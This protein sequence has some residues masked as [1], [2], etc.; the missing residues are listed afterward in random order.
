MRGR[1]VYKLAVQRIVDLVTNACRQAGLPLS[2]LDWLIPHQMNQRII[3]SACER[4]GFPLEKTF[5]NI[6]RYGNTSSASVPL[7][8]DE[9]IREGRLRRG[10]HA[11]LLAIGGGLAWGSLLLKY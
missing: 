2:R 9:A 11:L 5:I 1:E 10:Q 6:D 4:L 3:E 7:A 8:L